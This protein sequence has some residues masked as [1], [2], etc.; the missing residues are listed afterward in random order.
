MCRC[1]PLLCMVE[2]WTA[3]RVRGRNSPGEDYETFDFDC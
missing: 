1:N 3:G 2:K